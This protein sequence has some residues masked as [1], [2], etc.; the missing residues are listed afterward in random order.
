[1]EGDI[2][3]II[4][5]REE[6]VAKETELLEMLRRVETDISERKKEISRMTEQVKYYTSLVSDMKREMAPSKMDDVYKA[7]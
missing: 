5:S 6:L 3:A 4:T 2:N 1:M 7:I